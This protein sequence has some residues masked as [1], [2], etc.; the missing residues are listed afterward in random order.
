MQGVAVTAERADGES[1]VV[2]LLL[3]FFQRGTILE[4]R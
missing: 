3:E 2:E 4:H 1:V